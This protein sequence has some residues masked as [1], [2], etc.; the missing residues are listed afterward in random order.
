MKVVIT[1]LE[2]CKRG[3][4][5]EIPPERVAREMDR[6][7]DDYS[8][9]ARIPGFRKGRIPID[10]VRRRFGKEVREEVVGSLVREEATRILAEKKLEPVEPPI[11]EEV[12][13]EDGQ[14]L[15]FRA[16]FEIFPE[17]AVA[18]YKKMA[19]SV[20]RHDVTDEMVENSLHGMAERAAKLEELPARP[21]QKGDYIVGT[22]SCRFLRGRGKNLKD[23]KLFL[24]AGSEE[25][26]PDFNAAILGMEPGNSRT[27]EVEYPDDYNAVSLRGCA[28]EYQVTL[29]ELKKKVVPPLDD[30]LAREFGNFATLA[31]LRSKV[32]EELERRAIEAERSEARHRIL[33]DLVGRHPMEVP[34]SLVESQL[35]LRLEGM[36]REMIARGVDPTK[37]DVNWPEERER[38]RPAAT[39]A[40]RAMLILDAIATREGI[41]ASEDDVNAWLREEARRRKAS[42]AEVKE[43]LAQKARLAGIRRQIVREKSL[44]FLLDDATITREVR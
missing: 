32:R 41:E 18:D 6:A 34:S 42:V 24:E 23:E 26:H 30:D 37:A 5:V 21:V 2:Q 29:N 40:V 8:R 36:A 12:K 25:N 19:V 39:D 33:A 4:E 17:V 9:H 14:P 20:P 31:E 3:L 28:V 22:L 13:Y 16:T 38:A 1:E 35:D 7:F 27:F 44:D 11:L 10:V 15:S 43:N